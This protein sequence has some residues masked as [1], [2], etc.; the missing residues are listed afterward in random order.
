MTAD[1]PARAGPNPLRTMS[2][3]CS[4]LL[5]WVA[6]PSVGPS[7]SD[8]INITFNGPVLFARNRNTFSGKSRRSYPVTAQPISKHNSTQQQLRTPNHGQKREAITATSRP[9]FWPLGGSSGEFDMYVHD[10]WRGAG[11]LAVYTNLVFNGPTTTFRENSKG[12]LALVSG[13]LRVNGGTTLSSNYD[14]VH[15]AMYLHSSLAVFAGSFSCSAASHTPAGLTDEWICGSGGCMAVVESNVTFGSTAIFTGNQQ[16]LDAPYNDPFG[17]DPAMSPWSICYPDYGEA[18][19]G[20]LACTKSTITF[21]AAANFFSNTVKDGYGRQRSCE[22]GCYNYR[23]EVC[24]GGGAVGLTSCTFQADSAIRFRDNSALGPCD[25]SAGGA[26]Q[27]VGS[28]LQFSGDVELRSNTAMYGGGALDLERSNLTLNGTRVSCG[29]NSAAR[30]GGCASLFNSQ[31]IFSSSTTCIQD[32]RAQRLTSLWRPPWV[33]PP[34]PAWWGEKTLTAGLSIT[35]TSV[36]DFVGAVLFHNNRVHDNARMYEMDMMV[37]DTATFTCGGG[38]RRAAGNY[39]VE[40]DMCAPGCV[41]TTCA[42]QPPND[43]VLRMCGDKNGRCHL[44]TFV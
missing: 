31:A 25:S 34:P 6:M 37:T 10:E 24:A 4:H 27:A 18:S 39:T 43:W 26:V 30:Q 19:G 1:D 38:R 8:P 28:V 9:L 12:A 5:V 41:G 22:S 17:N 40:G 16:I 23:D 33:L 2:A 15:A 44:L 42:E 35:G 20:A 36:A 32:N 29:N 13:T 3:L 21:K 14:L 11:V 7:S